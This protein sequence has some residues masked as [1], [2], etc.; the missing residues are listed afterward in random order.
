MSASRYEL[1]VTDD[2]F[3]AYDT[4]CDEYLY[5]E[6]GDNLFDTRAEANKLIEDAV[7][8]NIELEGD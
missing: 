1:M 5:N 8:T 6:H 4:D 3:M 2:G 7:Y